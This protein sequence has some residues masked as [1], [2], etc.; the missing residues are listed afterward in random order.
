MLIDRKCIAILTINSVICK[1]T[2]PKHLLVADF[3]LILLIISV[4]PDFVCV[5]ERDQSKHVVVYAKT[6]ENI[7]GRL[8]NINMYDW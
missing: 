7:M 8:I 5:A 3:F 6:V 2:N 4:D 1:R